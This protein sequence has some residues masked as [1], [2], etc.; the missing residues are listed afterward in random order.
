MS[1]KLQNY[2]DLSVN[3]CSSIKP[4]FV[5]EKN[6]ARII[7]AVLVCL[8]DSKYLLAEGEAQ[9]YVHYMQLHG[10]VYFELQQNHCIL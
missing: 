7:I 8:N 1:S 6:F 10:A 5:S 3:A 4:V 2:H 9:P